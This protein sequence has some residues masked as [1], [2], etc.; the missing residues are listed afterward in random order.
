MSTLIDQKE[1]INGFTRAEWNRRHRKI[2]EMLQLRNIDCLVVVG[3][4]A[5]NWAYATNQL[6]VMGEG[7]TSLGDYTYAVFPM[8]GE[9]V[10][11]QGVPTGTGKIWVGQNLTIPT[12]LDPVFKK[13]KGEGQRIKD[14]VWGIVQIV[15]EK[16]LEKGTIG[17]ADMRVM[18]AE[19]YIQMLRELPQATFVPAGDVL[20]EI[21]R[22]KSPEEQEYIRK[23]ALAADKGAGAMIEEASRP[24]ATLGSVQMACRVGML[25]AGAQHVDFVSVRVASWEEMTNSSY[26]SRDPSR[27][28]TKGDLIFNEINPM[29]NGLEAQACYPISVGTAERDMPDSLTKTLKLHKE[30]YEFVRGEL[31]PGKTVLDIEREAAKIAASHGMTGKVWALQTSEMVENHYKLNYTEIQPGMAYVDHP[32]VSPAPGEK[33]H[34]GIIMGNTLIITEGEPEV[35]SRRSVGITVV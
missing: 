32:S 28:V 22:I 33:G 31:K 4:S 10:Q 12:V 35:T 9:P 13:G 18:P 30:M 26:L 23:A 1:V 2:R 25:K 3:S 5:K 29:V 11:L 14:Y 34:K 24:G 27:N 7:T 17:I 16:G 15:K 6:Y 21:R 19:V 20:L 8:E